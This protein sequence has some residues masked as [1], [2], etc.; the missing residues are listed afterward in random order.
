MGKKMHF[1]HFFKKPSAPDFFVNCSRKCSLRPFQQCMNRQWC[2]FFTYTPFSTTVKGVFPFSL[3]TSTLTPPY[4][5]YLRSSGQIHKY[6]PSAY[7]LI[8]ERSWRCLRPEHL[9]T[10]GSVL[11]QRGSWLPHST[12]LYFYDF[13]LVFVSVSWQISK[14]QIWNM[15]DR[16][17]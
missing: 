4:R 5:R 13:A 16:S 3:V 12:D 11:L 9:L 1:L 6:I 7:D 15:T 2:I 10:E 17:C 14:L 8:G